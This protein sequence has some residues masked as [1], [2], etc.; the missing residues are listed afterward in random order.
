MEL[1]GLLWT[2]WVFVLLVLI[3]SLIGLKSGL[4]REFFTGLTL[5]LAFF[6]SAKSGLQIS[7]GFNKLF[8]GDFLSPTY[9]KAFAFIGIV[10]LSAKILRRIRRKLKLKLGV[11]DRLFGLLF[12][13]LR[14]IL[15][16][17][18]IVAFNVFAL[19]IADTSWQSTSLVKYIK[20][21]SDYFR[22]HVVPL[23]SK[24]KIEEKM[25]EFDNQEQFQ[26]IKKAFNK[27]L[28]WHLSVK[29]NVKESEKKQEPNNTKP[30]ATTESVS[31]QKTQKPIRAW[32]SEQ[33]NKNQ[34]TKKKRPPNQDY[35]D[36]LL[37]KQIK[38][39]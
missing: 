7:I 19:V 16:V 10:W 28:G 32:E 20:P 14:G 12:G 18:F 24:N 22:D 9:A 8:G 11:I 17:I 29:E 5:V 31:D 33:V 1:L 37:N 4:I 6:V 30:V 36:I 34:K 39:N 13:F 23:K 26:T 27:A 25:E 35:R 2:D 3:S 15:V 21:A 38:N